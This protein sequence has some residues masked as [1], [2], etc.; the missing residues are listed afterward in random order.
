MLDDNIPNSSLYLATVLLAI[1]IPFSP[2]SFDI[3]SSLMGLF[4]FSDFIVSLINF[5][6][7]ILDTHSFSSVSIAELKK[8]LTDGNA[9]PVVIQTVF[10]CVQHKIAVG[11]PIGV[12][13]PL[14]DVIQF[15]TT[16][17]LHPILLKHKTPNTSVS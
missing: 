2:K 1:C 9:H 8:Y 4:L 10:P 15:Q 13:Q 3:T 11:L 16:G 7:L 17:K 5:F 6:I 14:E 12:V